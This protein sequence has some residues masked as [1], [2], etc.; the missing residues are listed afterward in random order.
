MGKIEFYAYCLKLTLKLLK[1]IYEKIF[2]KIK[3]KKK[4]IS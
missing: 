2:V 3:L 1:L 4:K